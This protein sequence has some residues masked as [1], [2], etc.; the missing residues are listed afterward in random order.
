MVHNAPQLIGDR[1]IVS[2]HSPEMQKVS[3]KNPPP[4][5]HKNSETYP[6][7]SKATRTPKRTQACFSHWVQRSRR[8]R[9]S[10]CSIDCSKSP[11]G[12][13]GRGRQYIPTGPQWG[14]WGREWWWPAGFA[15]HRLEKQTPG[16]LKHP[17]PPTSGAYSTFTQFDCCAMVDGS[18][19]IRGFGRDSRYNKSQR[20]NMQH[21]IVFN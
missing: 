18:A 9:G 6:I 13:L 10:D 15:A 5:T 8:R 3:R 12:R 21:L 14:S 7:W 2:S 1:C 20:W 4:H 11:T 16:D 17:S 19:W